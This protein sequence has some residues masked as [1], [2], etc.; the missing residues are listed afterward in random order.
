MIHQDLLK[1]TPN[2]YQKPRR[3]RPT[4]TGHILPREYFE[5]EQDMVMHFDTKDGETVLGKAK[6]AKDE[7]I[8]HY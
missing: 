7:L 4:G 5:P 1:I 3:R 6:R 8:L 2:P